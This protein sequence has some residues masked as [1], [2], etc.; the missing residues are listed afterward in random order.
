[1]PDPKNEDIS[2]KVHLAYDIERGLGA[3]PDTA[4]PWLRGTMELMYYE[5]LSLTEEAVAVG[6]SRFSVRRAINRWVRPISQLA[7]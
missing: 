4:P 1:M 3:I 6:Q 2:E 5:D 7:A